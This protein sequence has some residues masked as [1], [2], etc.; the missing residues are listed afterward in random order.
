[1][2]DGWPAWTG[3]AI[4]YLRAQSQYLRRQFPADSHKLWLAQ[5]P[6]HFGLESLLCKVYETQRFI[7]THRDPATCVPS[8][9]LTSL[10]QRKLYSDFDSVF[11]LGPAMPAMFS[12]AAAAQHMAWRDANPRFDVLD[13]SFR[14]ITQDAM[15]AVRKVF[16]FAGLPI[17]ADA[18]ARVRDWERRNPK[19]KHVK[20]DYSPA[21]MAT[22]EEE[23]SRAF[24]DYRERFSAFIQYH[25]ERITALI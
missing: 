3:A 16:D 21:S 14:E 4:E 17:T 13:L 15:A 2:P 19:D 5:T 12:A 1:M 6:S 24:A 18:E 7:V 8:I 25:A 10:A 9:T 20:T 23:I 11:S 22:S